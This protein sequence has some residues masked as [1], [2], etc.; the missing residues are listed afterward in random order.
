MMD[1]IKLTVGFIK[2]NYLFLLI[3]ILAFILA[4][5]AIIRSEKWDY[6]NNENGG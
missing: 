4:W 1:F 3:S 6:K 5:R 2:D